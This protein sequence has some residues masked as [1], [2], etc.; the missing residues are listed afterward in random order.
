M[1]RHQ[2][3][4]VLA[5]LGLAILMAG[6]WGSSKSTSVTVGAGGT[7]LSTATAVGI[8]RCFNCHANTAVGGVGIFDAWAVSRHGNLDNS[9]DAWDNLI[10]TGSPP[11]HGS[12]PYYPFEQVQCGP[13]HD[14]NEDSLNLALYLGPGDSTA[15]RWVVGCEGCHGGG[16]LHF[17]VGPIGGPKLGEYAK[18]ATAGQSSQYNTCTGCHDQ[19]NHS[20]D[21]YR[22]I[23]DTHF[24]NAV[25]TYPDT[26]IEGYVIRKAADTSCVDCHNPHSA[27][28]T[29]NASVGS[30]NV[31]WKNSAHG[32]FNGAAWR[33][34][35][36]TTTSYQSCQ[37]CHTTTGLVNY[38]TSPATYVAANNVYSWK[39]DPATDNR[40]EMLY[41]YGCHT[42]Y[43]GG[44]RN[45]GPI[46]ASY[47]GVSPEPVYPDVKGSN[48]CMACHTGREN[49]DSVK[50]AT[51]N[52]NNKSFVNSHYLTA[53]ATLFKESGYEFGTRTYANLSAFKHDNVGM[54]AAAGTG[55]NGPCVGCHMS[56]TLN[57][58]DP[59]QG[60]HKFLNVGK[61]NT[62]AGEA[63]TT[64]VCAV[65]HVS[66]YTMTITELD[67]AEDQALA[68]LAVL[69]NVLRS[70]GVHFGEAHPYFYTA[71]YDN[72]YTET[73]SCSKNLPVKNWNTGGTSTFTWNPTTRQCVSAASVNG[74][75]NTG[76][77][78]M[79]AAF[80][81]NLFKHDPGFFVHNN[82]YA[83]LLIYDAIDLRDNDALDNSVQTYISNSITDPTVKADAL[84]FFGASGRPLTP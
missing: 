75:D 83:K 47:S 58:K 41:C 59:T 34:Y 38:L 10:Q 24:D 5:A 73:G 53:G 20:A 76:R 61:D 15:P 2:G 46:T 31:Q 18:P 72:T 4:F 48:I 14:P 40:A 79:G 27:S 23:R 77:D 51:G 45:P 56:S 26:T 1:K 60:K 44:L 68:G 28:M 42:N 82:H 62:G 36:W 13:C 33:H 64:P 65:C 57:P 3:S 21:S 49:G 74:T 32:D 55:V 22:T 37:R 8:D 54:P 35:P 71:P 25:G 30:P 16:S 11:Y 9:F 17:G 80:N 39:T 6:C 7:V 84:T 81:Y 70:R 50:K 63:I 66:P 43:Y 29:V 78:N 52:F 12:D 69:D 67:E 19:V